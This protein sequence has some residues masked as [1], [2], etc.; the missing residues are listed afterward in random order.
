MRST[1]DVVIL[2]FFKGTGSPDIFSFRRHVWI[3]PLTKSRGRFSNFQ[4][5]PP[6][7]HSNNPTVFLHVKGPSHEV[8]FRNFGKK[9]QTYSILIRAA[10]GF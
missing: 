2:L 1:G 8:D 6:I 4:V 5:A 9:L 10:A 7:F 3:E